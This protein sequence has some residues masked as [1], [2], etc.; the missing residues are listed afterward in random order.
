VTVGASTHDLLI[1]HGYKL[2]DDSGTL[3]GRRTYNHNDDANRE[4]IASLAKVLRSAGWETHPNILR[5]FRHPV[6]E[7]ALELESGGSDVTG[8]FLHRTKAFD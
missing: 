8:H 3:H 7:E 2:I 5:A 1:Q 6:T 4:F